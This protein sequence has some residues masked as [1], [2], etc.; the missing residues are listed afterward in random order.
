MPE[1]SRF[2]GIIIYMSAKDHSPPHFHAKYGEHVATFFIENGA[3]QEGNLPPEGFT[4][5]ERMGIFA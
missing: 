3:L 2:Y 1:L 4:I 5:S